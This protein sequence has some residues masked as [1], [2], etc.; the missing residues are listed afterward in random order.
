MVSSCCATKLAL[1]PSRWLCRNKQVMQN[2][3]KPWMKSTYQCQV[4]SHSTRTLRNKVFLD[5]TPLKFH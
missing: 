4:P 1:L 5:C 2:L 3:L